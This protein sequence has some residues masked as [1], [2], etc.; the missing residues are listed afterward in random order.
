MRKRGENLGFF[1]N[2]KGQFFPGKNRKGQIT[3]FIIIAI[4]I[5]ALGILI[6]LFYPQISTTLGGQE[7]DPN[8]FIQSCIE[9]EIKSN[10]DLVSS[11]GGSLNPE[12]YILYQDE[13]IQ[14]LCYTE[15]YSQLCI[16]QKPLLKEHIESEIK[17]GIEQKVKECF[18]ELKSSFEGRG[19]DVSVKEGQVKV[20]LLPGWVV[21]TFNYS[22]T[23]TKTETKRY[24]PFRVM[25]NNNLYE[26]VSIANNIIDWESTYGDAETTL[27]M[28]L[29]HN[30]KVEKKKPEYGTN[31]YILTNRDT[32]NKFQFAS[33]SLV[34]APGYGIAYAT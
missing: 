34:T 28:D 25:V 9:D 8:S 33:R 24:E 30:L 29:Y 14:Y 2:E 19:Y 15:K 16:V 21:S 20:E 1:Y 23:L 5:V 31:I 11:Q 7:Q 17:K 18:N 10:V 22:V 13:K 6:Y 4:V 12:P 26:L 3:I 32:E 27:Y